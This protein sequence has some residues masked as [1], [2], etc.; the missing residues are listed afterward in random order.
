MTCL[1][2][3]LDLAASPVVNLV[4]RHGAYQ[5]SVACERCG[6]VQVSPMPT[7]EALTAY[8]ASGQYRRD[9]PPLHSPERLDRASEAHAVW[10]AN[11]LGVTETSRLLEV[12]CGFGRVAAAIEKAT[13]ARV[14][15][16]DSDPDMLAEAWSRGLREYVEGEPIDV[17][18][19]CQVLEHLADPIADLHRW[20]RIATRLHVELPSV[21]SMYGGPRHFFQWPHV[22]NYS[23]RT[24]M[25]LLARAGWDVTECGMVATTHVLFATATRG[26]P[27][28]YDEA[29]VGVKLPAKDGATV[30]S[31]IA[32]YRR[33]FE[34]SPGAMLAAFMD[35]ASI[36][37]LPGGG[38]AE[39][40]SELRLISGV[41]GEAIDSI[42]ALSQAAEEAVA[43]RDEAWSPGE[44]G[45][46]FSAGQ[47][48]TWQ[49]AQ[50][51]LAHLANHLKRRAVV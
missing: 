44:W 40:R 14:V 45:R 5:R 30:A 18:Y 28:T 25:L 36:G 42:G 11:H 8:Y 10:L 32:E 4:A 31:E 29:E 6:L 38:E 17:V 7:P 47:A 19:A 48:A 21:E 51:M 20:A 50:Q 2:C 12:G 43:A 1:L 16:R 26:E 27:K 22:V 24:L 34:T 15:V 9:F 37:D 3:G 39:V 13:G 35:G 41:V 23:P 46:G 33:Q 49:R